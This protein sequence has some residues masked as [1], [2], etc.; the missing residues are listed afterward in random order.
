ML[1]MHTRTETMTQTNV[2]R[3]KSIKT[4]VFMFLETP[5]SG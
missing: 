4:G 3:S 1:K 2:A 5:A